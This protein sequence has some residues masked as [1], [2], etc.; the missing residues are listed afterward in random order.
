LLGL[1]PPLAIILEELE[2][3]TPIRLVT[4]NRRN[5]DDEAARFDAA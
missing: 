3:S 2:R 5:D 1:P 4:D